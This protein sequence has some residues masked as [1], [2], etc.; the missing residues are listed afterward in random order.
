PAGTR[1]CAFGESLSLRAGPR[2]ITVRAEFIPAQNFQDKRR[3]GRPSASKRFYPFDSTN[4]GFLY[5][6]IDPSSRNLPAATACLGHWAGAGANSGV[7]CTRR[8][9]GDGRPVLVHCRCHAQSL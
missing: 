8:G 7:R 3:G 1:L 9:A 5:A 6:K 4:K 2:L